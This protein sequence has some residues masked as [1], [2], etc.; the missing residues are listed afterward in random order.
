MKKHIKQLQEE[1]Q[2]F[3]LYRNVMENGADCVSLLKDFKTVTDKNKRLVKKMESQKEI[4]ENEIKVLK[5]QL[6]DNH[7]HIVKQ[8]YEVI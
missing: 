7:Y 2:V 8:Q 1:L 5:K 6:E 3:D 4:Y